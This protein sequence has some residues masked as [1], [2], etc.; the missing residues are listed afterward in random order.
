MR[1]VVFIGTAL[2]AGV[3]SGLIYGSINLVVTE[4]FIDQA[5][6]LETKNALAEG[7]DV[8]SPEEIAHYRTWQKGGGV[9]AGSIM[10]LSLGSL[11]A[12]VYA[13]AWPSLRG[14]NGMKKGLFLAAIIWFTI[15]MVPFLKY[16]A[17]PPSVGDPDTI[18]YR[19]SLYL[20]F[21]TA[22][23]LGALGLAFLY[24]KL[25]N[26]KYRKFVIPAVYAAYIA[27]VFVAMPPNPDQ[28]TAPM[29]LVNNFRIASALTV[30][31]FWFILGTIFGVLWDRFKPHIRVTSKL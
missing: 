14:S 2:L 8:G 12:L 27:A 31:A 4:P 28:I 13:F 22:S 5:I 17:N 9:L 19:Q 18:Y 20:L 11:F 15:F 29:Q 24:K 25:G 7:R 23:G 30:T 10:G 26:R 1:L 3:I 6:D 21:I 16:P